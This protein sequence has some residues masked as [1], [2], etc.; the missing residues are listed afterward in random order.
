MPE[1]E[2]EKP[3][4]FDWAVTVAVSFVNA[5]VPVYNARLNWT[6]KTEE[7]ALVLA[8]EL[9][10][11]GKKRDGWIETSVSL[12]AKCPGATRSMFIADWDKDS[13]K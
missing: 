12:R 1:P 6:S 5:R 13:R 4:V 10:E 8:K 11:E 9:I 2:A 3:R 7:E